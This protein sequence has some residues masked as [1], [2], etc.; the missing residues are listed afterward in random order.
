M[1]KAF[2]AEYLPERPR[3]ELLDHETHT[4]PGGAAIDARLRVGA[5]EA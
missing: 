4:T 1:W 3:I 2:A 5:K